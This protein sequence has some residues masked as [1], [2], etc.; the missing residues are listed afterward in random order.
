M[1]QEGNTEEIGVKRSAATSV[2]E[3]VPASV[4]ASRVPTSAAQRKQPASTLP[5]PRTP[6]TDSTM[7]N[8]VGTLNDSRRLEKEE[9]AQIRNKPDKKQVATVN[10]PG[11]RQI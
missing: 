3:S 8:I 6:Q 10:K 5:W 2:A 11:K 1:E 4:A 9:A 7:Q